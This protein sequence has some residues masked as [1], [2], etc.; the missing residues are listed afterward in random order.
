MGAGSLVI[1]AEPAKPVVAVVNV[2]TAYSQIGYQSFPSLN[3]DPETKS[4]L[5]KLRSEKAKLQQDLLKA[6]DEMTLRKI[7]ENQQFLTSKEQ[8][9]RNSIGRPNSG[10][11]YRQSLSRF[12]KEH[13][14][15]KYPIIL[16]SGYND[17]KRQAIQFDVEEVD[18]TDKV[19]EEF[20]KDLDNG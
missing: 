1:A 7:N 11:D 5:A 8:A 19:V 10:V 6:S 2:E 3:V 4:A 17:W 12:I 18:I 16:I 9:I 20:V 14:G 15:K 13:F